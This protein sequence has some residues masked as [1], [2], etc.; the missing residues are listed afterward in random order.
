MLN[1]QPRGIIPVAFFLALD[2]DWHEL[3]P[4]IAHLHCALRRSMQRLKGK[5]RIGRSP[6]ALQTN[7]S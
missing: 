7:I 4:R 1:Y 2:R 5:V 3:M 6:A